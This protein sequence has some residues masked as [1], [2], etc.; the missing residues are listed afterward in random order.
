[1]PEQ[2]TLDG[3]TKSE[4]HKIVDIY[5]LGFD[6][7]TLQKKKKDLIKDMQSKGKKKLNDIPTKA[8]LKKHKLKK[9]V[10]PASAN[11]PNI[12]NYFNST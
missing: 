11:Q 6:L 1:M 3:Y 8:V 9:K 5:N 12:K 2:T 4:L 7:K 10:P